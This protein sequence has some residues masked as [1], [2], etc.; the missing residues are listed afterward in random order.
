[1]LVLSRKVDEEIQIGSDITV[2]VVEVRGDRVR[3]GVKAPPSVTV[4]RPDAINKEPP[5]E[6]TR[7]G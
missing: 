7:H 3:L 4:M 1:M 6:R 5:P 2:M